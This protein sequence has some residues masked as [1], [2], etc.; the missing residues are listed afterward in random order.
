MDT[1][2]PSDEIFDTYGMHFGI[3]PEICVG[4]S[5]LRKFGNNQTMKSDKPN[6]IIDPSSYT[7]N[8]VYLRGNWIWECEGVKICLSGKQN[9]PAVIIKYNSARRVHGIIGTSD[10][11]LGRMES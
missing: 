9:N 10:G 3:A 7:D 1:L 8:L 2:N 11:K 4:Y 5:K 6:I